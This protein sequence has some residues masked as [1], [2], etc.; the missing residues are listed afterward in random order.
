[1]NTDAPKPEYE[2]EA[3]R[4][5]QCGTVHPELATLRAGWRAAEREKVLEEAA[6]IVLD[7]PFASHENCA[8]ASA[9]TARIQ[10]ATAIRALASGKA[11]T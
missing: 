2:N 8:I 1:M 7:H 10:V 6:N 11:A 9:T 5:P 4:C 3:D